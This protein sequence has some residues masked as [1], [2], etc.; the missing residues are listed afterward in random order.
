MTTADL[1][2]CVMRYEGVAM[3]KALHMVYMSQ[4]YKKMQ[5]P[6]SRLYRESGHYLYDMLCEEC[7]IKNSS[8]RVVKGVGLQVRRRGSRLGKVEYAGIA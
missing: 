8:D 3:Q 5:N 2:A 6:D 7:G 4:L 1:C